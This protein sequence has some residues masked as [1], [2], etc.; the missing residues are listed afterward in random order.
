MR[1]LEYIVDGSKALYHVVF[2]DNR[3]VGDLPLQQFYTR[4]HYHQSIPSD[5]D[6][7]PKPCFNTESVIKIIGRPIRCRLA[8]RHPKIMV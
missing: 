4:V 2:L 3:A 7:H 8:V 5:L 1:F 6:E